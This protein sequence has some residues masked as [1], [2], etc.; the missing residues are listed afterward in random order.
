MRKRVIISCIVDDLSAKIEDLTNET[1]SKL[2]NA[3]KQKGATH[4]VIFPGLDCNQGQEFT[5]DLP[6]VLIDTSEYNNWEDQ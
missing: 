5:V 1:K 4:V 6:P 3:L 2:G